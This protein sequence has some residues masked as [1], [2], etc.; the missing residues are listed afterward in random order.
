VFNVVGD[1][2]WIAG[3]TGIGKSFAEPF[4]RKFISYDVAFGGT[5]SFH[6]NPDKKDAYMANPVGRGFHQFLDGG[7]INDTPL[8]NTEALD[9][10]V[11]DP[12]GNYKPM[13]F[14]CMGRGWPERVQYAGTYDQNWI[15]NIFPFLPDDFDLR[16]YQAAPQDQQC[17]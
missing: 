14:G 15:D 2:Y 8:P 12:K 3:P 17:D 4:T 1:R 5:D 6:P 16:Y 9:E 11:S 7:L 10:S 13:S